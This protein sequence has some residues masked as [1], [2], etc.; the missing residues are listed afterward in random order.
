MP[1]FVTKK[2][3]NRRGG[4]LPPQMSLTVNTNKNMYKEIS[5][6]LNPK[7]QLFF[8]AKILHLVNPVKCC[9]NFYSMCEI[10]PQNYR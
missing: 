1:I 2:S 7:L 9:S 4:T 6:Q 8:T 10:K 5:P 3:C